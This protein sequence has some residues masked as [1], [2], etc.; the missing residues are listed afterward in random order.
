[1]TSRYGVLL[2]TVVLTLGTL[3]VTGCSDVEQAANDIL[4]EIEAGGQTTP[5]QQS[6]SSS[7]SGP[8]EAA[9]APAPPSL[10]EA[11]EQLAGLTVGPVGSMTGYSRELFPHW[12]SDGTEFGWDE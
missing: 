9:G 5:G 3:T 8:R 1:M 11:E 7:G 4:K 10:A 2:L 6:G 12:A